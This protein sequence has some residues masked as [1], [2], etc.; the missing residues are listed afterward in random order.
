MALSFHLAI[1]T[2]FHGKLQRPEHHGVCET[3]DLFS[4]PCLVLPKAYICMVWC[5]IRSQLELFLFCIFLFGR[6]LLVFGA[7]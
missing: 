4:N 1:G 6:I 2:Q 5:H 7:G 3:R